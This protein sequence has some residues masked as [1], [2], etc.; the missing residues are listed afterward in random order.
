MQEASCLGEEQ[1]AEKSKMAIFG[2]FGLFMISEWPFHDRRNHE[3]GHIN[4]TETRC[5]HLGALVGGRACKDCRLRA[6]SAVRG[7]VHEASCLVV[8]QRAEKQKMTILRSVISEI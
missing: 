4:Q 5:D 3:M 2:H 7:W 8:E 1:R 6:G